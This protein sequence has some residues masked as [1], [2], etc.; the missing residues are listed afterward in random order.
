MSKV[1]IAC[2][3]KKKYTNRS[4]GIVGD[5]LD[6]V[7]GGA[8]TSRGAVREKRDT[9]QTARSFCALVDVVTSSFF[10]FS[11][12]SVLRDVYSFYRAPPTCA[13]CG[14]NILTR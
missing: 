13:C 5:L 9:R 10:F 11:S 4:H 6:V 7:V 3:V 14:H 2:R 8:A 1:G 12:F